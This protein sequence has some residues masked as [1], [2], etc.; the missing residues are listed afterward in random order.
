[1]HG[2]YYE[3]PTTVLCLLLFVIASQLIKPSPFTSLLDGSV[4][5]DFVFMIMPE[6]KE[7]SQNYSYFNNYI[8]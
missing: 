8:K 7:N 5:L 2:F 3:S 1:M 6:S 4:S